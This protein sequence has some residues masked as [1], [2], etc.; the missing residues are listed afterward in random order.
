MLSARTGKRFNLHGGGNSIRSFIDIKDVS[1]AT[2]LIALRG[3]PG[4]TYHISSRELISIKEIVALIA[5]K[6]GLS[7]EDI[8]DVGEERLGK[9]QAYMLDSNKLRTELGWSDHIKIDQGLSR[10]LAWC[11]K[12]LEILS[13]L[14][15]EYEHKK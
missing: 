14:P 6:M 3:L 4:Q 9:D 10:T 7:L 12:N 8:A 5:N 13:Q 1:I 11:D 15:N 2:E